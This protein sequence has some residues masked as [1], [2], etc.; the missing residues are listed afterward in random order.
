MPLVLDSPRTHSLYDGEQ[1]S[2]SGG[3]ET[4]LAS[5]MLL[6]Y[7]KVERNGAAP[8]HLVRYRTL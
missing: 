8:V 2:F 7:F 4:T 3:S 1:N 5:R 6:R